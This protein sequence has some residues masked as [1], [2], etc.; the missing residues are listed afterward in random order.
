MKLGGL[1]GI[2]LLTLP[3]LVC[4][5]GGIEVSAPAQALLSG[6]AIFG[7]A[8]LLSWAA[9]LSQ[10]EISQ[11]L[12]LAVI[13]L[14]AGLPE[15]SVDMVFAIDAGREDRSGQ[16]AIVQVVETRAPDGVVKGRWEGFVIPRGCE[17]RLEWPKGLPKAGAFRVDDRAGGDAKIGTIGPDGIYRAPLNAP[18][19]HEVRV[20]ALDASESGRVL[21]SFPI[22]LVDP[23]REM[24]L[25]NM[26]GANRLL[27]GVGWA[28][29]V[30]AFILRT[31]KG[32]LEL[33]PTRRIELR[34]LAAA[35]VYAMVLPFKE[36]LHLYDAAI[37]LLIFAFYT[38]AA[39]KAEVKEPELDGTA[40]ILALLP[41]TPRRLVTIALFLF[42]GFAI[43]ISAHPFAHGLV[44][45]GDILNIDKFL[46][47]QWI[48]PIAS[49]APEFIVAVRFAWKRNP[50]AGFG[51]VLSSKVNQ[52]TLLV[53]ML[54]MTYML[55]RGEFVPLHFGA[56]QSEEILLTAAQSIFA[57]VILLDLKFSWLDGLM[58][59]VLFAGQIATSVAPER[60]G[61]T[62]FEAR[63][64]F[65]YAYLGLA[66]GRIVLFPS[67]I[68]MLGA[69]FRKNA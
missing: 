38:R 56:L 18:L 48:A 59:F 17:R 37:L 31:R 29:V 15:Y 27:I 5:F 66:A 35:S 67:T 3:W 42:S 24:A 68:P 22:R 2:L 19:D 25:A 28:V 4:R 63:K 61:L 21:A 53:G 32:S 46:L 33:S 36:T 23:K 44:A 49:E 55:A 57:L 64:V 16:T 62:L 10:L 69:L 58:L 65:A 60:F 26:T 30:F 34:A 9:E 39:A 11:A 50:D 45:T 52:W 12:A 40:A 1:W 47:V 43:F 13:A 51:T 6:L 14:L 41:K 8:C 7:A 54:P 20:S